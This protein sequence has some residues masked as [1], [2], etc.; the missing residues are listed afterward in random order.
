MKIIHLLNYFLP[1]KIGGTEIYVKELCKG[2]SN[3][4][5]NPE[6]I[7]PNFNSSISDEYILE[8]IKVTK[9]AEPTLR[10]K[11]FLKLGSK[12]N[13]F[14]EFC[15]IIINKNPDIVHIHEFSYGVG[16]SKHHIDFLFENKIKFIITFHIASY[17]CRT[18]TMF[19]NFV[20]PCDGVV[21]KYK[22]SRCYLITNHNRILVSFLFP[23]IRLF[24]KLNLSLNWLPSKFKTAL[25]T[26][27]QTNKLHSDFIQYC[28][29]SSAI[30]V[31]S[32]WFSNMLEKN[33][34]N[35]NKAFLIEQTLPST[36]NCNHK[37][38]NISKK[39]KVV[40]VGRITKEKGVHLLLDA[41]NRI[42]EELIE[43]YI[44][45]PFENDDFSK[46][47]LNNFKDKSNLFWMGAIDH[48]LILKELINYDLLCLPSIL[49]EMS[50][51]VI[52]EAKAIKLPVIASNV[53]GNVD[54]IIHGFN[55]F[56][57]DYN[58]PKDLHDQLYKIILNK[59][60]L[61]SVC[62]NIVNPSSFDNTVE[63]H[64]VIYKNIYN[65]NTTYS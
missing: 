64:I 20:K 54:Q 42:P 35:K 19:Q 48:S 60:L 22:C 8:G 21:N 5:F 36:F 34:I 18:G 30:I 32:N 23:I 6:V 2:L 47:C 17:L 55:G 25:N 27:S 49:C 10:T 56:I 14:Q 15:N 61:T 65:E 58:N 40:F 39:L 4:G 53:P 3:S 7:V 62:N 24:F 33:G 13:G 11:H 16:I 51:L 28:T 52:Q 29:K 41:F 57:F 46:Y 37:C 59:S 9:Y 45:G 26:I 43:L 44:Y 31:L 50:S 1:D 12:P 38:F 63:E